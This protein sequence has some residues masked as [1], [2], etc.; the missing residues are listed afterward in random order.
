MELRYAARAGEWALNRLVY[1]N[2][3]FAI[4]T[5]DLQT[6]GVI[7]ADRLRRWA[8]VKQGENLLAL[9][10][11]RVRRD[12]TGPVNQSVSV[13]RILPHT[14]RIRIVERE[15]IAQV[16]VMRPRAG[17]GVEVMVYQLD[18]EG[19]VM[20]PLDPRQRAVPLSQPAE[21]LPQILGVKTEELRPGHLLE[22]SI[23]K[24]GLGLIVAFENSPMAGFADLKRIDVSGSEVLSVTTGQNSEIIFGPADLEQQLRRWREIFDSA[25][26]FGKAIG[27]LD[28]AITNNIPV[29]WLE[30][31]ADSI[32]PVKLPKPL[33]L[34]KKH[35]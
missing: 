16:N 11:V 27:T 14:L 25:Q 29:R 6:D 17:G 24:A 28:L 12:S 2:K 18:A 13:E 34:R 9:D 33:H 21:P 10:L 20:V 22:G 32:V 26:K 19:C 1:E 35:V 7:A 23:L 3:A 5:I 4:Q 30:A 15:P 8:G 31:S